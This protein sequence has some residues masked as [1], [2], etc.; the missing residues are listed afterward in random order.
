MHPAVAIL[1]LV[2]ALN[3][4]L[5]NASRT[6]AIKVRLP[7]FRTNTAVILLHRDQDLNF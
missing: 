6:Q 5:W 7:I 3:V 2:K 4:Q 1:C